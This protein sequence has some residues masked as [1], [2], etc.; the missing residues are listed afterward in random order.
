VTAAVA[1]EQLISA[2]RPAAHSTAL[3][4]ED[5]GAQRE[6]VLGIGQEGLLVKLARLRTRARL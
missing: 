6:A 3:R 2:L 1:R 4:C 5:V